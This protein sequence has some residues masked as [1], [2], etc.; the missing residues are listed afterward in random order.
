MKKCKLEGEA[1]THCYRESCDE[2][3]M[4]DKEVTESPLGPP[5]LLPR[6]AAGGGRGRVGEAGR[7]AG[8]LWTGSRASL[9]PFLWWA[10]LTGKRTPLLDWGRGCEVGPE[11]LRRRGAPS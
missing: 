9:E 3:K 5:V 2:M 8:L 4:V 10:G 1:I 6:Q 11:G 7:G